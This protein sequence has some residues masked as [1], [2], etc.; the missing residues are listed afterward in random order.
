MCFTLLISRITVIR[1]R[2]HRL[3]LIVRLLLLLLLLK[4]IDL[5]RLGENVVIH[6]CYMRPRVDLRLRPACDL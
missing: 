4:K 1:L 5:T 2:R 6:W 3:L